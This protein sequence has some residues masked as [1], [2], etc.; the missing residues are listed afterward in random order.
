MSNVA[1]SDNDVFFKWSKEYSVNIP[2]I[3][4]QHKEL[5][6]ILNR[7]F[8]AVSKREGA[9]VIAEILDCLMIYTETHFSLEER[10]MEEANYQDF[11]HHKQEHK[12]LI[13]ELDR[14]SKKFLIGDKPI[15]FELLAF[16]RTWLKAHILGCDAKYSAA[17]QKAQFSTSTWERQAQIEFA[18][19]ASGKRHWWQVWQTA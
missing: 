3:D 8:V 11:E 9:K 14:L 4:D 2:T 15:Y 7:L 17:L 16:L 18:A 10:L 6:S 13:E 12:K 5:V 19:V 1:M